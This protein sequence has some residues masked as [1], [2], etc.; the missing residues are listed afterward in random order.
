MRRA[1]ASLVLLLSLWI[2]QCYSQSCD[3]LCDVVSYHFMTRSFEEKTSFGCVINAT[4]YDLHLPSKFLRENFALLESGHATICI[5][6]P[7]IDDKRYVV[8]PSMLRGNGPYI[9]EEPPK[10]HSND[11]ARKLND[12]A[13][14]NDNRILVIRVIADGKR[15]DLDVTSLEDAWFGLGPQKVE[16]YISK[17]FE[18]CSHGV[19]T[20]IPAN[21][22]G[23][24]H[25]VINLFAHE[26][27]PF[28]LTNRNSQNYL[29]NLL[30]DMIG[31]NT[32]DE[33]PY[34]AWAIPEEF[35]QDAIAYAEGNQHTFYQGAF[36]SSMVSVDGCLGNMLNF[37]PVLILY[38][39][40]GRN[41]RDWASNFAGACRR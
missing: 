36:A 24:H 8:Y 30:R 13:G 17:Q 27:E 2:A 15:A 20:P 31:E 3:L 4:D 25:G 22:T 35:M 10:L 12:V 32:Y 26:L 9:I 19:F 37:A 41:A 28:G 39:T 21:V 7:V 38:I 29:K 16:N 14:G 18:L 23:S 34:F 11:E 33:I 6:S 40:V 5:P 1:A